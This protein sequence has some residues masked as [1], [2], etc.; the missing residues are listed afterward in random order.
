MLIG[1]DGALPL[2]WLAEPLAQ[3]LQSQRGHALMLHGAA[4]NGVLPYALALAQSWL[5]EA[6]DGRRPACGRC[7]SCRLVQGRVHPDL[8][9]LM[10]EQHRL[11][12]DWPLSGDKPE[13]DSGRKPSRQIRVEEVRS[14]IDWVF[15]TSARGRGKVAVLTP[16]E[17]LNAQS[18]NALLKTLE[19]PPPGTRLIVTTPDPQ[20]LLPTVRSRCQALRLAEPAT[21][22]ALDWLAG[23]GVAE[24]AVLLAAAAGRPLDALALHQAGV[25]ADA[26]GSCR[27]RW[28]RGRVGRCRAGRRRSCSTCCSSSATTRWRW[29]AGRHRAT[30]R[31]ARCRLARRRPGCGPGRWNCSASP[32]TSPTPGTKACWPTP[33][34]PPPPVRFSR[35]RPDRAV[36]AAPAWIHCPHE[37]PHPH[38]R[39][40]AGPRRGPGRGGGGS[41]IAPQRHP[42][43]V[44]R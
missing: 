33:W 4:G 28:L 25:Q 41:C 39:R 6:A 37:R 12:H 3:S 16:G 2:P 14:L 32:A 30:F 23:H 1:D 19:E 29:R 43:R 11:D 26:C 38:T 35:L 31:L 21:P 15:K 5:C 42:A 40:R 44:S 34:W 20:R 17:A 22:W 7:G 13:G 36:R 24:P 10:P 18:T 27:K 9:L 8:M